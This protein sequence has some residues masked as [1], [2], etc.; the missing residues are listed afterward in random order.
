[1]EY[2]NVDTAIMQPYL[3]GI[4]LAM[5]AEERPICCVDLSPALFAELYAS[6]E[7]RLTPAE[8]LKRALLRAGIAA[9]ARITDEDGGT[10]NFDSPVLFCKESGLK[11][12]DAI[13][14]IEQAGLRCREWIVRGVKGE[15]PLIISGFQFGQGDRRSHM[16]E[17]F[18][19]SLKAEG[20]M[21]GMYYQMD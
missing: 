6:D 18:E 12:M 9:A 21:T 14:A 3:P 2:P 13:C 10:C 20:Y 17:A 1:M 7:S 8:R 15:R 4:D 5:D 16:A 19:Q 11:K